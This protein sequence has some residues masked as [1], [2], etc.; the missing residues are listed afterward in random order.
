MDILDIIDTYNQ[1][2]QKVPRG[3]MYIV[4]NFRNENI[5]AALNAVSDFS[6]GTLWLS[7][8]STLLNSNQV[9]VIFDVTKI[10]DFLIE[11]NEGL[12]KQDYLLV[13]DIFEYEIIPFFEQLLPIQFMV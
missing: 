12:N 1:Y 7:E 13:A 9:S 3:A 11:I 5:N 10:N 2:I 8:I 6:E 4:E